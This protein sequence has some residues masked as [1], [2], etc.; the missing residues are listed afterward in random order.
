MEGAKPGAGET[1]PRPARRVSLRE[2]AAFLIDMTAKQQHWGGQ[3]SM[4]DKPPAHW[5]ERA[6]ELRVEARR[7]EDRIIRIKVEIL[8]RACER[9]ALMLPSARS[10]SKQSRAAEFPNPDQ[11]RV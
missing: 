1:Y 4:S 5:L 7:M 8:A 11:P 9:L 6:E 10:C 2:L 3:R